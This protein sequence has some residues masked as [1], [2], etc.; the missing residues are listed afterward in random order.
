[1]RIAGA[2]AQNF[3][4]PAPGGSVQAAVQSAIANAARQHLP[5]FQL[6]GASPSGAMSGTWTRHGGKLV[7]LGA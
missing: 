5:H 7:V 3:K 1:V 4:P 2:A 6:P